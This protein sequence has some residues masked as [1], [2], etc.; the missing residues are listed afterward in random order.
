QMKLQQS[1]INAANAD[2]AR[3]KQFKYMIGL[4]FLILAGFSYFLFQRYKQR[5]KLLSENEKI[6]IKNDLLELEQKLL[7]T[8]MN[9]HFIFNSLNSIKYY[10][11]KNESMLAADY[12]SDFAHLMRMILDSSRQELISLEDEKKI[13]EYYLKLERVRLKDKFE[14]DIQIDDELE[15]ELGAVKIPPMLFQPFV[16]NAV[17]HGFENKNTGGRLKI[18]MDYKDDD[19]IEV[20]IIDDGGG[21]KAS[22]VNKSHKSHAIDITSERV[23]LFNQSH[24]K[25]IHF[26]INDLKENDIPLGTEVIFELPLIAA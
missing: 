4:I 13:L 23:T 19:I 24:H 20:K 8:Q 10:I 17:K 25:G 16:E 9:P 11:L 7:L 15:Q 18:F 2:L 21:R 22:G 5:Q 14:F 26:R 3:E 6:R 1:E 12:L